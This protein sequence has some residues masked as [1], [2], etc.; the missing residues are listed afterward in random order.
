MSWNASLVDGP[1]AVEDDVGYHLNLA[2]E[3]MT[4]ALEPFRVRPETPERV[5]AGDAPEWT[6]TIFL[7][8]TDEAAA[9]AALP[10]LWVA[11]A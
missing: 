3:R 11:D 8:F 10:G 7:R 6:A 5:W 9:R 2:A 1:I 4:A